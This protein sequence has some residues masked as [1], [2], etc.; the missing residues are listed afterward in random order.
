MRKSTIDTQDIKQKSF[1]QIERENSSTNIS[2]SSGNLSEKLSFLKKN[3]VVDKSK[4]I[5]LFDSVFTK[6]EVG[7]AFEA[8]LKTEYNEEPLKFLRA[9]RELR[10]S[11]EDPSNLID[12]VKS[13]L[14]NYVVDGAPYEVNISFKTKDDILKKFKVQENEENWVLK[15][16]PYQLFKFVSKVVEEELFHDNWK[17]FIRTE[18]AE[19][20]I[21]KYYNEKTS[22]YKKNFEF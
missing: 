21:L 15:Q 19:K 18:P 17:R 22:K 11:K 20:I 2:L 8:Y 4:Y 6:R 3:S 10:L 9:V 14:K 12:S 7:D 5:I 1:H 16:K 13:I